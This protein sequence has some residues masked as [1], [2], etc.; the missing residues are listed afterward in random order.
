MR[1][2]IKAISRFYLLA[3]IWFV[4]LAG[5]SLAL[6]GPMGTIYSA[7]DLGPAIRAVLTLSI[8]TSAATLAAGLGWSHLRVARRSAP[9]TR[10]ASGDLKDSGSAASLV[11][12]RS[13][14][15]L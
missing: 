1:D 7:L 11:A 2:T 4:V 3:G 5:T 13:G 10:H 9:G 14:I 6:L 8:A 12:P 15:R